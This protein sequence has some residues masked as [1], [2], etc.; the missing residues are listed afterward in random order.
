[1]NTW[2]KL[3]GGSGGGTTIIES[4]TYMFSLRANTLTTFAGSSYSDWL[5]ETLIPAANISNDVT[6]E[7]TDKRFTFNRSGTYEVTVTGLATPNSGYWPEANTVFGS[8]LLG[9]VTNIRMPR[10]RNSRFSTDL[11]GYGYGSNYLD[12]N[13]QP[14]SWTDVFILSANANQFLTVYEYA[15]NY[16]SSN[17]DVQFSCTVVFKHIGNPYPTP[18]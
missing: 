7:P 17:Q 1:M 9:T 15:Q 2:R 3:G 10:S 8:E 12:A 5:L 6:W 11:L 18:V 14:A 13:N 4:P 16:L